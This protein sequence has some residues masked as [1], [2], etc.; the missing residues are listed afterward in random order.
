MSR[1][2]VHALVHGRVQGVFFRDY[3]RNRAEELGL[4]GWVRNRPDRSVETVFEG[5]KEKVADMLTWLH[6]GS[7]MSEVTGVDVRDEE[8]LGET[9]GFAIRY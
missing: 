4:Q 9:G 3:T 7:P 5:E 2:R 6:N 1:R 8:P